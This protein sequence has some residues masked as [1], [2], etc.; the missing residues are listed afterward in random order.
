MEVHE[1]LRPVL[2]RVKAE[3]IRGILCPTLGR[4]LGRG[5]YEKKSI[6]QIVFTDPDWFFRSL[7]Q[8]FYSG[9][10]AL[11]AEEVGRRARRIR[12]QG[13]YVAD[14]V[15]DVAGRLDRLE[16]VPAELLP[17]GLRLP[18]ID[19]SVARRF[20]VNDKLGNEFLVHDVKEHLFG[21]RS[22]RMTR[23]RCRDFFTDDTN[24][25]LGGSCGP[26]TASTFPC[27]RLLSRL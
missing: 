5:K 22:Y 1:L 7:E 26:A 15:A 9:D 14:Y 25:N 17:S 21:S 2:R 19:L 11:V 6:A 18:W 3:H 16:L 27:W 23:K 13:D 24:F 10:E 12:I 8:Q 4:S 20:R